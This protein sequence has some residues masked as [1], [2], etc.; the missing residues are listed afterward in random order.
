MLTPRLDNLDRNFLI[1]G[2]FDFW[3][4]NTSFATILQFGYYADRWANQSAA[5]TSASIS[6]QLSGL[7]DSTYCLRW[8]AGSV[9]SRFN[10]TQAFEADF[11]NKLKGK[12]AT[13]SLKIRVNSGN[14][15]PYRIRVYNN[16]V[17]NTLTGGAFVLIAETQDLVPTLSFQTFSLNFS[18]PNDSSANGFRVEITDTVSGLATDYVEVTDF[19]IVESF[20]GVENT[21]S[22][23]VRAGGDLS[24]EIALCNR[25]FEKSYDLD[26]PLGTVTSAGAFFGNP[27]ASDN[28]LGGRAAGTVIFREIKRA[29]V[30]TVSYDPAILNALNAYR[31]LSNN[32]QVAGNPFDQASTKSMRFNAAAVATATP[33]YVHWAVDAEIN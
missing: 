23:Y 29:G 11:A 28:T 19:M 27:S 26:T 8:L 4:R 25:Y 12:S 30:S 3:Q 18:V 1:N 20:N 31:D 14:V 32:T 24:G 22:S 10:I 13:A 33:V 17:A 9:T 21:P 16:S 7:Q 2:N 6:R 5:N 15:R